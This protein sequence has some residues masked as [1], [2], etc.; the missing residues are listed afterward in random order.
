[1]DRLVLICLGIS[2]FVLNTVQALGRS[3]GDEV[4]LRAGVEVDHALREILDVCRSEVP[5]LRKTDST[6][7]AFGE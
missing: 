1:L 7:L 4:G 5:I 3:H 6:L 2:P